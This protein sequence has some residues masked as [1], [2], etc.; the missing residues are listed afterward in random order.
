MSCLQT[1]VFIY[2]CQY[3]PEPHLYNIAPGFNEIKCEQV[4]TEHKRE[5]FK[6]GTMREKKELN[7]SNSA[8]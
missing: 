5:R 7:A 4:E 6:E 8:S 1:K 3:V 2:L